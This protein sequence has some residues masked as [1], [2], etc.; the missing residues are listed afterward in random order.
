MIY[1]VTLSNNEVAWLWNECDGDRNI[2]MD[3][4]TWEMGMNEK[5]VRKGLELSSIEVGWFKLAW[6]RL[7]ETYDCSV[8][9]WTTRRQS[10]SNV[11]LC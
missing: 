11:W 5:W 10:E 6:L 1:E 8:A 7:K 2:N 4:E 3:I 9:M